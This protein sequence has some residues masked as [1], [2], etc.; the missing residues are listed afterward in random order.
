MLDGAAD[1]VLSP[2]SMAWEVR[3]RGVTKAT[4]V[5]ALLAAPPFAGRAPVFVGDD[6]TDEDGMRAAREAGG[7]GLRVQESFG[8]AA[9]VRAWLAGLAAGPDGAEERG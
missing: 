8:D 6:V 3:P 9:G 4:A 2:A 1:F 5:R 7:F